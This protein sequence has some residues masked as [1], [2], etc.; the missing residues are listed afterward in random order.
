MFN[1]VLIFA[2]IL[3]G[4]TAAFAQGLPLNADDSNLTVLSSRWY[5]Q[6]AMQR[7]SSTAF[8][9]AGDITKPS[10]AI[11]IPSIYINSRKLYHYEV[12]FENTT[13]LK[14]KGILWN[15][16][17]SDPANNQELRRHNFL[18]AGKIG[19]KEKFTAEGKSVRSPTLLVTAAGLE[20]DSRSPYNE[21][22]EITC[23]WFDDGTI[24]ERKNGSGGR[25][26]DLKKKTADQIHT[27]RNRY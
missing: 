7:F 1:S 18:Y 23:I 12:K 24:W 17:F 22:I 10:S 9:E 25:C 26:G 15:Y 8:P 13:G 14:I 19:I 3:A 4:S 5:V 27:L 11:D 21:R 2:C 16:V 6:T 20:K